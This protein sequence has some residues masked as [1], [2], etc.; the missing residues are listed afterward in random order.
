MI[1]L[2]I[3]RQNSSN[4]ELSMLSMEAL[5]VTILTFLTPFPACQIEHI[6]KFK[7]Q[8]TSFPHFL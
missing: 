8:I 3:Q 7:I 4:V 5:G 2:K 6:Q 1:S